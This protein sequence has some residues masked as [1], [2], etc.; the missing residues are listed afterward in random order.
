MMSAISVCGLPN[1]VLKDILLQFDSVES[2]KAAAQSCK[3]FYSAIGAQPSIIRKVLENEVP[4][5]VLPYAY[6]LLKCEW[7]RYGMA[8]NEDKN[9]LLDKVFDGTTDFSTFF[10]PDLKLRW[11]A[12]LE[13][14]KFF[15][16]VKRLT[17]RAG[18]SAFRNIGNELNNRGEHGRLEN[19]QKRGLEWLD[20][21]AFR[22]Y[23]TFYRVELHVR[24]FAITHGAE[25]SFEMEK[26]FFLRLQPWEC[27]QIMILWRWIIVRT[28]QSEENNCH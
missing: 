10:P 18:K 12:A 11:A 3:T 24:L 14:S 1:D 19:F 27:E 25:L 28:G 16:L 21:E 4:A 2:L 17:S 15:Q 9:S 20:T 22:V 23:L 5:P 7:E 6:A 13:I 26:N 8:S